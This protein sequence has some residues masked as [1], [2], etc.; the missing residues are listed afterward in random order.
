MVVLLR[1]Q[2]CKGEIGRGKLDNVG[3]RST[4]NDKGVMERVGGVIIQARTYLD[5]QH[6]NDND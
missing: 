4:N 2:A 1:M 5:E 3:N 6:A